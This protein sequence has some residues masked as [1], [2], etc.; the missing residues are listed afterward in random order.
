MD[1]FKNKLLFTRAVG[2]VI[3]LAAT[4]CCLSA[5][6]AV[7]DVWLGTVS[8]DPTVTGNWSGGV[9]VI[10]VTNGTTAVN[11]NIDVGN[12][13]H[14]PLV[15]N[16]PGTTTTFTGSFINGVSVGALGVMTLQSGN[17]VF[18]SGT[19]SAIFG[20]NN[21]SVT[22][23]FAQTGGSFTYNG[24]G[25]MLVGNGFSAAQPATGIMN[26]SGG[27][28]TNNFAHAFTAGPGTD[29]GLFLGRNGGVGQINL[30]GT[31]SFVLLGTGTVP[32]DITMTNASSHINFAGSPTA[33]LA[34]YN[35][36]TAGASTA[37]FNSYV[38]SGQILVQGAAA[39]SSQFTN[40]TTG[41]LD[42]Y[43]L[44]PPPVPIIGA[45]SIA[46][47]TTVYAGTPATLSAIMSFNPAGT[48]YQWQ[49]DNGGGG[50]SFSN[51]GGA[52]ST[53]YVL[54]TTSL[55][56]TYEYQLVASA[57]GSVTSAPVS[58]SVLAATVP[59]LVT[60]TTS[61]NV[62]TNYV[63]GN[64][65]YAASFVGTL[66]ITY[67]W[68]VSPNP[69]GSAAIALTSQTNTS[70]SLTNLQLTNS[71]YY[72]L[73]A[74]NNVSPFTSNSPWMALT[75]LPITNALIQWSAPVP[76]LGLT[77]DQILT[78]PAGSYLEAEVFQGS[79]P[80]VA[81]TTPILVPVAGQVFAFRADNGSASDIMN[82]WASG[83]F[84]TNTTGNTN[85][86][87]VLN[88]SAIGTLAAFNVTLHN[89]VIG[90]QYSVQ[91][92]VLDDRAIAGVGARQVSFQ[93]AN[94][95]ADVSAT[96]TFG[97]SDYLIGTFTAPS[98]D[99]A[100]QQNSF[101]DPNGAI[102]ANI[103]AVV[104]RALSYTPSNAPSFLISP[105]S[106]NIYPGR[107]AQFKVVA[108]GI[109]A[110]TYQWQRGPVG[111]PYTNLV[112]G[113]NISGS[114]TIT[115]TISNATSADVLEY[116]MV[117]TNSSGSASTSPADLVILP[118]PPLSGAYSTNV[119]ALNPVAYWPLN[120]N[121]SDPFAGGAIAYDASVNQHDGMYLT[122]A[123][124]GFDGI[125][126]PQPADGYAQFDV[127]QGALSPFL[128]TTNSWATIPAL[129]LNTNTVTMIAWVKPQ[130]PQNDFTGLI[131]DNTKGFVLGYMT[132][133]LLGYTVNNDPATFNFNSGLVI[134][135]N[136]WSMVCVVVTPTK[137]TLYLIN[138]NGVGT[139]TFVH[140]HSSVAW[141]GNGAIGTGSLA[142]RT[143]NGIV[144]EVAVFNYALTQVQIVGLSGLGPNTD[145]TTAN[146]TFIKSGGA[147]S[148]TLNFTWA[149][150]HL[151]W[152]LYTNAVGL[153]AASSWFPMPGSAAV[154]NETIAI[155]PTKTNVFYQLRYP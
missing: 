80:S 1:H 89:L 54:N 88:Q 116:V 113:G 103:S 67:Q 62:T 74:S 100:I 9:P 48:T 124:D 148:P 131:I 104:V 115:L 107:T 7:T 36:G 2:A 52:T 32:A 28:F 144:D 128:N 126:G 85:F 152:Q 51:I 44:L 143:L 106:I 155:D 118:A 121:F 92:F 3:G 30:S 130:G 68:Q 22:N 38:S 60:N 71:G 4:L 91:L 135:A 18:N 63:G 129:N 90:Q 73:Q 16:Q 120:D 12:G 66:P 134:P 111:G 142:N 19:G 20:Q 133:Q 101:A 41:N 93:D 132:N 27:T 55:L 10:G 146:F 15:W 98:T 61:P 75:V 78:N 119:L 76:F 83:F 140:A 46:P 5:S 34:L 77:A 47:S 24:S 40:W 138:T 114:T 117:A 102:N 110:P 53:N 136:I 31:G 81:N 123:F 70:L 39:T 33:T 97:S 86:D 17:L 87:T 6:A 96:Y 69:D 56:G 79:S 95:A 43:E 154:T 94:D 72:S 105:Q 99:V 112:D 42:V 23:T 25:G 50:A 14:F 59:V 11:T 139:A 37:N 35:G 125:V 26:I 141:N 45:L 147:G 82:H 13:T 137:A 151:G 58:L 149:P 153:T 64:Q 57:G 8:S 127:G 65:A 84:N 122:A 49:T 108:D 109:P 145:A 21:K 150:D 29:N